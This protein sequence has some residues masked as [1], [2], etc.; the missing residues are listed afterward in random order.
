MLDSQL[1]TLF[2]D[3]PRRKGAFTHESHQ[4]TFVCHFDI[5]DFC[6][7]TPSL[8]GLQLQCPSITGTDGNQFARMERCR[9]TG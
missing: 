8:G 3:V 5:G 1:Q 7:V 9:G 6:R 4:V 2:P